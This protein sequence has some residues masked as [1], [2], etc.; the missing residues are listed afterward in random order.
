MS[1]PAVTT[2]TYEEF[3]TTLQVTER[4]L[5]ALLDK[6]HQLG[7]AECTSHCESHCIGHRW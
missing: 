1:S 6:R 4:D 5:L 3:L 7:T 2:L